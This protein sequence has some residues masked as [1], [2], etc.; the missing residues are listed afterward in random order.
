[1]STTTEIVH[2]ILLVLPFLKTSTYSSKHMWERQWHQM[3]RFQGV[4]AEKNSCAVIIYTMWSERKHYIMWYCN[5]KLETH[6]FKGL[7]YFFLGFAIKSLMK[8]IYLTSA[9]QKP[10][11]FVHSFPRNLQKWRKNRRINFWSRKTDFFHKIWYFCTNCQEIVTYDFSSKL[12]WRWY[13]FY[14]FSTFFNTIWTSVHSQSLQNQKR[15]L[16]FD[17]M[18]H[19]FVI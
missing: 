16:N 6:I 10:T 8:W 19:H 17:N 13:I 2:T 9:T 12:K 18:R 1:M 4:G 5:S 11:L 15:K 3:A 7:T 14:I